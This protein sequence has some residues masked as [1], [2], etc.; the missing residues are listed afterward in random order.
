MRCLA[1]SNSLSSLTSL[2]PLGPY[3]PSYIRWIQNLVIYKDWAK[4]IRRYDEDGSGRLSVDEM[5]RPVAEL[6]DLLKAEV[7]GWVNDWVGEWVEG[8]VG[9]RGELSK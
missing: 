8:W 7:S 1:C 9:G 3:L 4:I 5:I 6:E 2:S